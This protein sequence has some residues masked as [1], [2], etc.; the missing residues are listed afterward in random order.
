MAR[1]SKVETLLNIDPEMLMNMS[2]KDLAKNVS[3]LASAGNKRLKRLE[4]SGVFSPSAEY[5]KTRGG[6]F[7]VAGKNKNQLMIEYF[8]LSDFMTAKTS[9]VRG[10]RK[11]QTNVKNAVTEAV[12][13]RIQPTGKQGRQEIKKA[14]NAIFDDKKKKEQFWDIYSRLT[15][16]YD[17]KEK[18]KEVWDNIAD[19]MTAEPNANTDDIFE[20]LSDEYEANYQQNAPIDL[21]EELY[22]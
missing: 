8:R 4:Q 6:N 20:F 10:A 12:T 13:K 7:S 1:Q 9:S 19:A 15:N 11:W 14:I 21:G 2:R 5:V 22:L 16:E 17:I 3:I 18:Y